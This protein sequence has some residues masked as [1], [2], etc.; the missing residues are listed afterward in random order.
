MNKWR[1]V[2]STELDYTG[3][4]KTKEGLPIAT[5]FLRLVHGQRGAYVEFEE[6]QIIKGNLVIPEKELWRLKNLSVYYIE[7]RSNDKAFVKVYQQKKLEDYADYRP[8]CWY[9]SPRDLQDFEVVG[10]YA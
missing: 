5:G 7:H 4:I 8:G 1:H 10:K 2:S 3:I 9:I 6:T